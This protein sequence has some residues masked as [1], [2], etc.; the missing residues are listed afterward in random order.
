MNQARTFLYFAYGSNMLGRRMLLRTPS[1]RRLAVATLSDHA[2]RWHKVSKDGSGKCDIEAAPG[3]VVYGVLYEI[4]AADKAALDAA[5]G[6]SIGYREV[7][8]E[9]QTADGLRQALSYQATNIDRFTTPY[10][11]YKTLVVAGAKEQ[12][13]PPA[14]LQALEAVPAREDRDSARA[15]ENLRALAAEP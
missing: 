14:Y 11:W 4:E 3:A 7:S 13:L 12:Q 8:L 6:L 9:V 1:A 15:A 5:E 10:S 2:L